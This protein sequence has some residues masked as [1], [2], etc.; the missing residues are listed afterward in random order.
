MDALVG[1]A[2]PSRRP[3]VLA[4]AVT[5]LLA[6]GLLVA[7]TLAA[8]GPQPPPENPAAGVVHTGLR[9]APEVCGTEAFAVDAVVDRDG[10]TVCAHFDEAP[11]GVD[12]RVPVATGDLARRPGASAR[13]WRAAQEAG[14]PAPSTYAAASPS[15]PCD[16]DGSSG[17]RVQAMYVV[18]AGRTNRYASLL[19]SFQTWAGGVDDVV[20]RSAALTSGVRHVRYVTEP[21]A[22][23]T[24]CVAKVLNVTVPAGSMTS[25]NATINAVAA[26]GYN[27]ASRKYLM[28]TDATSLC[29]I[30]TVYPN[31]RPT[32]DNPN[33]GL[34][35]QYA[36]I[37]SGCWGFGDGG[38]AHSVEAHELTHTL[39]SVLDGAPHSTK[40][41][42]CWDEA[43]TMC[44]A[45]GGTHAMVSICPSDREYLLDCNSD[46]YFSTYPDP[47]SWLDQHWNAAN[48]RFL[49]G[50]GDGTGGGTLGAP[51]TLGATILVN[52][53]EVPG[54]P[55][56]VEI[57]PVLPAGDAVASVAWKAGRTDCAFADRT[58]AQTTV[59]CPANA[60]GST[61]V[62]ATVTDT[63]G[64]VKTVTSPLTFAT[65]ATK[66]PVTVT[67]HLSGQSGSTE[68]ACTGVATPTAAEVVDTATGTPVRGVSV[69][70]TKQVGAL[71]PVS[72][73]S[74]PTSFTGTATGSLTASASTTLRATTAA[75]GMFSAGSAAAVTV[76]PGT[77]SLALTAA[78]DRAATYYADPVT[79]SGTLTRDAAALPVAGAYV[80]LAD[81]VAG[82][83][84]LLT[85]V[86]TAA[87]G[88]WRGTVRPTASGTLVATVAASTG[89]AATTAIAGDLTVSLPAT[90][91]TGSAAALDVGYGSAL[92]A[93]GTLQ[94]DAGGTVTPLSGKSVTVKVTP[95]G[96]TAMTIGSGV[97]G[98][99][100]TWRVTVYPRVSGTLTAVFAGAAG[101]PAASVT[102]GSLT[103]GTWTPALTL[104]ARY[105]TQKAGTSNVFSGSVTRT[106]NGTTG[107][108]PGVTVKLYLRTAAGTETLLR[109]LATTSTGT[110]STITYLTTGG[111]LYA[112]VV[113]AAGYAD[114]SSPGVAVTVTP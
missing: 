63:A 80:R 112:R 111:T 59:T 90:V 75:V 43:D 64:A 23:G 83:T 72:A 74:G 28:W 2:V 29:G 47:G 57:T 105:A 1:S 35:A 113:S 46:D 106:Y 9:W 73:G 69:T 33:N 89:W 93:T 10:P 109:S 70:F 55:T 87:D 48:S 4:A 84:V 58:A 79:M 17:Y 31:D 53:P 13:A 107:P 45:D 88:T 38:S 20:N 61:T 76:V 22:A 102:L 62:T 16:G 30:A 7:L 44:Y 54:L 85:T 51:T 108:A 52:N 78:A 36:R 19:P 95:P 3:A 21:D 5:A 40:A 15:V 56:Q 67:V 8:R 86:R 66:R 37:D 96:G 6:A 82:R 50:G 110:F 12:V 42:H 60:T 26:L 91:M 99:A 103:V 14:V 114:A 25:F 41:G 94:R 34:Y 68:S 81:V 104:A 32:Q 27:L 39:G 18:E 65:S 49:L 100:G 98:T 101:Q 77:C 71:A 97:V 92:V 24:G 11:P